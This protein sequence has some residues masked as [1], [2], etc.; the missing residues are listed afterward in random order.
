MPVRLTINELLLEAEPRWTILEAAQAAGIYIPALCH[1][2][3]LPAHDIARGREAVYQGSAR[4]E[5]TAEDHPGCQLCLVEIEKDGIKTACNTLISD[6]MVVRTDSEQV[7]ERRRINLSDILA[8][9]PHACLVCPQQEGCDLKSCISNVPE[10]ERCCSKF[11]MCELRKVAKYV[12][13]RV[14]TPPYVPKGLPVLKTEPLFAR[15]YNLCVNCTRCV[16]I[17]KEVRGVG[18]L[19]F[20]SV[21]GQPIVGSVGPTPKDSGCTFCGACVEVCPTG[22]LMDVN[23]IWAERERQLVPCQ[24]ACPADINVPYYISQVAQGRFFE[25]LSVVREKVPFPAT[26]G[27][28]CFRPCEDVCRRG[29]LDEP[30]AIRSLKRCAAE[31]GG[32]SWKEGDVAG[33]RTGKKVAVVGSGP[34]GTTCGYYLA[35]QGHTVTIFE[36]LPEPGGMLRYGIPE[37]RLPKEVLE[38]ELEAIRKVGVSIKTNAKV[39]SLDE[40]FAHGFDAIFV[41]LGLPIGAR[42]RI[43]GEDLPQVFNG[44]TFLREARLPE[45]IEL[46]SRV[47]VIGGG[48]V[49]IDAARTALRLGASE[50]IILYRRTRSDMPAYLEEVEQAEKEGIKFNFLVSP[51]KI[52]RANGRLN[53]ECFRTELV[54]PNGRARKQP[55][56][57]RDSKFSLTLDNLIVAVGQ[58]SS[59]PQKFDLQLDIAGYAEVDSTSL[60]TSRP[61]VF[62][63][64]DMVRGPSTVIEAIAMG[65]K[66]ANAIDRFLAGERFTDLRESGGS[67]RHTRPGK[68]GPFVAHGRVRLETLH[69]TPLNF[70]EAAGGYTGEQAIEEARR[71]L[72]CHLRLMISPPL[73][74]P[75]EWSEFS[76]ILINAVPRT[77][78]VFQLFDANRRLICIKGAMNIREELL[79]KLSTLEQARYFK[80]EADP[81]YAKRES[82]L[83]AQYMQKYGHVPEG[84]TELDDDLY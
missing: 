36:E 61:G 18:A 34:A 11:N 79:D 71:C 70:E 14:D 10:T 74:P 59:V 22:A 42:L 26:L 83:L 12:G 6:G 45:K 16:R 76:A 2:P 81:M 77:E 57:I 37:Y 54:E 63:G 50:V 43:E 69:A 39:E 28:V 38:K 8:R 15:D 23:V 49:A 58:Q 27:R 65:R 21:A 1:H 3:D 7:Q 20:T 31:H 29:Q 73:M 51:N 30:I 48:N 47:G 46:G 72:R 5:G 40:L 17:C 24:N 44:I 4:I 80:W 66:A 32:D 53:V 35:K 25:A 75:E 13:I 33:P 9:H 62:A 19:D 60:S 55:V 67:E 82:E 78:G 52:S 64:G 41:A 68:D 56:P 84:N